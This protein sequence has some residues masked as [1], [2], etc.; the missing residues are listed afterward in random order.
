MLRK[1]R[2]FFFALI[3]FAITA[4]LYMSLM[5][6]FVK[7]QF[8]NKTYGFGI[9]VGLGLLVGLILFIAEPK[10]TEKMKKIG[11]RFDKEISGY[12]QVDI[13]LGSI[14]LLIGFLIAFLIS[15]QLEKVYVVGPVL[16]IISYIVLGL[17]GVRIGIRSK[18]EMVNLLKFRPVG[19]RKDKE[20]E[21]ARQA[22]RKITVHEKN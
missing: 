17:I 2:R 4:T 19:D 15:S 9:A 11:K 8:G 20:A 21:K 13:I 14:G 6:P 22:K 3:G 16:S 5:K 1:I 7:L 12:S 18:D 10:V